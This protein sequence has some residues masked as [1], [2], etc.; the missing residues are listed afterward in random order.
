MLEKNLL[1]STDLSARA[2]GGGGLTL[3]GFKRY[4]VKQLEDN[5]YKEDLMY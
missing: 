5:D 1:K 2:K 4:L 3:E